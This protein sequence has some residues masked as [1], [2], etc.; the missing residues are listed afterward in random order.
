MKKAFLAVLCS[1]TFILSACE[2]SVVSIPQSDSIGGFSSSDSSS[3]RGEESL[4]SDQDSNGYCDDCQEKVTVTFDVY[5][6]NDLHGKLT[7]G[8]NHPGVDE[9]SAYFK[10]AKAKNENT[11][12]L[13]AGD[14]WQGAS[15]SNLTRGNIITEWMNEMDFVSMT[16]GNH[17]YDWGEDAIEN[18][19]ELAEFPF[20]ALNVYDRATN[21]R[22]DYCDSSVMVD[23][24]GVQI[25]IIGAMGDCYSSISADKVEDV[26]FV[27]GQSLTKLVK[28]EAEKLRNNGADFIIYALHDGESGR[29]GSY[30][31]ESLSNGYVD[32]VFEGHSHQ[33]YTVKDTYGV[34]HLQ[35]GGDNKG[36]SHASVTI[37][38]AEAKTVVSKAEFISTSSYTHLTPDPVVDNL[39][40]K[41]DDKIAQASRLLGKN[42]KLRSSTEICQT[43]AQLYYQAGIEKWGDEYDIVLGGGFLNTRAPYDL[44][45]GNIYYGDLVNVLPFDNEIVLCAIKGK[46]LKSRFFDLPDRYYI[47]YG[48][49]G[50]TV[51]AS[52]QNNK[53]YYL[54]TDRYTS[55]YSWN[56][57]TEI[58]FY[59]DTTYARDLLA[60]HI[61]NGHWTKPATL[62]DIPTLLQ[63]AQN[64][65]DNEETSDVYYVTGKIVSITSPE[66]YGNITIEDENGN[67]LYIFG[68]WDASGNRYGDMSNKPQVGDTVTLCGAMKKY[69]YNGN[70][71]LEMQNGIFQNL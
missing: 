2:V 19:A 42:D 1:L 51:K 18:N 55:Q 43:V 46:Y 30:Y 24:S 16:L 59:D 17:E 41:Y 34:Y 48:E 36:V 70:V 65:T 45:A 23:M 71:T 8:D 28:A 29:I 27:T 11:I 49:Y 69:V 56:N 37:N 25:G 52:I 62:T 13:S 47:S 12:L 33:Q 54:V 53:T 64:L 58:A 21:Q 61:E 14:M 39:L 60:E 63:I 20:L 66:K 31:D 3:T 44:S 57:L 68:T 67:R 9:L 5:S 4:H 32:L 10:N 22:V 6:V 35:G 15:E 7:D 38:V 50:E 40:A 26:Y